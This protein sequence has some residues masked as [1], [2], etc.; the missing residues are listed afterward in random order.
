MQ[1]SLCA[2]ACHPASETRRDGNALYFCKTYA[3]MIYN[4]IYIYF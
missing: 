1:R 4:C 2:V 3:I